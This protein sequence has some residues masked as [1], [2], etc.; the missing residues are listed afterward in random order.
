MFKQLRKFTLI[1]SLFLVF[2]LAF[3]A[4]AEAEV[5]NVILLI[6]DGLGMG[7]IDITRYL[8]G[9][10]DHELELMQ[11][12]ETGIMMTS[13]TEGVPDSAAAGTAMSTG[14]KVYNGGV[15]MNEEGEELDSVLDFAQTKNKATGVVSTNTVTDATPAAFIA[16]VED[17]GMGAEIAKQ[18][19]DNEVDVMFGGGREDF[20]EEEAGEDLIAQAQEN[21]YQYVSD[22]NELAEVSVT[23][24]KVLGLFNDSYMNYLNDRDDVG[25]NEPSL[26]EMT[27]KAIEVLAEDEDGFFLM[28]EGAR[29]D[30]ASHAADIPGVVAET[31]DFDASVKAAMD[32]AEENG[33]TLVIVTA[34]HE[35]L[36]LSA[37]EP[38]DKEALMDI[39]VSPEYMASQLTEK[40]N[41]KGYTVDSVKSVFEE[42][43]GF[44][45]TDEEVA[46]FNERVLDDDGNIKY[47]YL[48]GWE[49]GTFIAEE[50]QVGAVNSD[51]R[52]NSS[53][54]GHTLNSV[55][56]FAYGEGAEEFNG[57]MQNT[58]FAD[59]LFNSMQQ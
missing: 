28:A 42:Y 56:I 31:L 57:M 12:P 15:A 45:L 44:S 58:E 11:L 14:H 21:G 13:S 27:K 2:T 40:E 17:R 41:G 39:D 38:M 6:G 22:K 23:E 50:Y 49:I 26:E 1:A 8:V 19:L 33:D 47:S 10:K 29:I 54:G 3:T 5:K 9:G 35:T 7:Q 46:V 52:A 32:F 30:H 48:V 36:G 59:I 4:A 34:D 37:T 53:T 20:T 24:G 43:A 16:S 55:P 18:G 25:S 51:I